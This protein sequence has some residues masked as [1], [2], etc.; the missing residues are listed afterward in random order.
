MRPDDVGWKGV[1]LV[2]TYKTLWC[3]KMK[4]VVSDEHLMIWQDGGD[5]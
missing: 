5:V 3:D 2:G 1:G 4:V